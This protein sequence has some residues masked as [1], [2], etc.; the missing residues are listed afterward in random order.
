MKIAAKRLPQAEAIRSP[1]SA[2]LLI[3]GRDVRTA[4]RVVSE[5]LVRR[6]GAVGPVSVGR[7]HC[8]R[9][10]LAVVRASRERLDQRT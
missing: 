2:S 4:I 5:R 9:G 3:T 1:P 7:V 8:R 6:P 10:A